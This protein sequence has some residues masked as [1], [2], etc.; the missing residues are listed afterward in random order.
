MADQRA[1]L[2]E[3]LGYTFRDR[4]LLE[5]ALTHASTG[6]R[7]DNQRMEFLGDALLNVCAALL[8][9]REQPDW[10]EGPMS[11]LRG[12]LVCTEALQDWAKDLGLATSL[13][14]H[15]KKKLGSK[16]MGDAVEALLAAVFLDVGATGGEGTAVV[17][18]LVESRH[19]KTIREAHLG[20]WSR[21][22][23]KTTLQ[24]AA[25]SLGLAAP[26]YLQVAR[27]GPD[28]APR[29]RVK[30]AVGDHSAEGEGA[31]LKKAETEAA[32]RLLDILG[33]SSTI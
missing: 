13:G 30:A 15:S 2:E 17:L 9:Y 16:P 12:M 14:S 29:F 7:R 33:T 11:K 27:S 22:D 25:A 24:E 3:R 23:A 4:A 6:R 21:R 8:I 32:R 18:K 28:H 10:Q 19:L 20:M 26:I 1:G 31:T 5:E